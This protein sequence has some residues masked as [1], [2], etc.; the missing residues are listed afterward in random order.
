MHQLRTESNSDH[1]KKGVN[2]RRAGSTHLQPS[3]LFTK[4]Y[5]ATTETITS[6]QKSAKYRKALNHHEAPCLCNLSTPLGLSYPRP[7]CLSRGR[8]LCMSFCHSSSLRRTQDTVLIDYL[9][10]PLEKRCK[11]LGDSCKSGAG[12]CC[13]PYKCIESCGLGCIFFCSQ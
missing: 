3:L 1:Y 12:Q 2:V 7:C 6:H 10:K 13:R 8:P 5:L 11:G 4:H 9:L